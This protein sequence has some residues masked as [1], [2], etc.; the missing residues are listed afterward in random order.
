VFDQLP[1][2]ITGKV[3]RGR[4]SEMV[5]GRGLSARQPEGQDTG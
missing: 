4:L 2:G 5:R 1:K 3:L